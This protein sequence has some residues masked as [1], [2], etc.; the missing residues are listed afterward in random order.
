MSDIDALRR[1]IGDPNKGLPDDVFAFALQIVPMINVDLLVRDSQDRVLVA[2]REDQWGRG[3]HIPGGI[4]RFQERAHTRIHEVARQELGASVTAD[5]RPCDIVELLDHGRGHFI[6]MLYRCD[7]QDSPGVAVVA[8]ETAAPAPGALTWA[9]G[10]PD[11]LYPAHDI[12]R[13]WFER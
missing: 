13:R 7:L 3:W 10:V 8:T 9:A 2:W 12:Y 1:R 5:D 11:R 4:I 6:S